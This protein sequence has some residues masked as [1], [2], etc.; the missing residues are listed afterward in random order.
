M[1]TSQK[2]S[3]NKWGF[4]VANDN[5]FA[6]FRY[7]Q[8]IAEENV[9][10]NNVID[11]SRGDPGYGFTPS[12]KGRKFYAY[13]LM[14]D[15]FLNNDKRRF[16][17]YSEDNFFESVLEE[18]R[19]F[20]WKTFDQNEA[21]IFI[22]QLEQMVEQILRIAQKEGLKWSGYDVFNALFKFCP[23]S[24]GS[25]LNP[26][27]G[28]IVRLVIANWY[29]NFIDTPLKSDDLILFN[30]ASHAIGT[31]FKALG[32][33]G[34]NYLN[35][36]GVVVICSPAYAPYNASLLNRFIK[37]F[38][39]AINPVNGK[40]NDDYLDHLENLDEKVKA[41]IM[42]DPNNPTGF[43]IDNKTLEKIAGIAKK[44]DCMIISDEVYT[45]FFP[46]KKTIVDYAPERTLR[47]DARSKIE[48]STGLRFGDLFIS[49][50]ANEHIS[51]NILKQNL[52]P[53]QDL[54][55][56]LVQAKGPGGVDGELQHTTFVSGPA[57]FLGM[58]HM[59]FG[60]DERKKYFESVSKHTGIFMETLG[61]GKRDSL[62]YVIFD[63]NEIKGCKKGEVPVEEKLT[64]LA[65]LGVV[66]LPVYLFFSELERNES[67]SLNMVRASIV[68][69]GYDNVKRAA[70]ITKNYL[71]S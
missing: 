33:S 55:S 13:L 64:E 35:E 43:S 60:G 6:I 48:R 22:Q 10:S 14:L 52:T 63:M 8:Q 70:E 36:E 21:K 18:I 16:V 50:E 51:K 68:N 31:L 37:T 65:K 69:T 1:M 49:V 53:G 46:K 34:V 32:K 11:L 71:S 45:S 20:S 17:D 9:D 57:Q 62:Y 2:L 27:G 54:K 12:A 58:A 59:I 3:D 7:L 40:I 29:R 19:D 56:L 4:S 39:L 26:Q 5:P 23:A 25:Y 47:I 44:H 15:S 67:A 30:G 42:V 66:Y 38:A 61:M 24:G 41:I 28:K